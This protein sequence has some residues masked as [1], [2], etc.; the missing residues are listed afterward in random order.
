MPCPVFTADASAGTGAN[1][2]AA[3]PIAS[4]M[5]CGIGTRSLCAIGTTPAIMALALAAIGV[6]TGAMVAVTTDGIAGRLDRA[7]YS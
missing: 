6:E 7:V 2:T 4:N 5:R 3:V 1:I